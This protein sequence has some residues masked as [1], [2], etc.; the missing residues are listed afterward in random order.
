MKF[1]EYKTS[2]KYTNYNSVKSDPPNSKSSNS[3][4]LSRPTSSLLNR[5]KVNSLNTTLI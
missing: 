2:N 3:N 1:Q 5:K 4:N